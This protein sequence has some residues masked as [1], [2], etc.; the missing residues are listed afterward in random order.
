[1]YLFRGVSRPLAEP[2]ESVRLSREGLVF[3][4][5][6]FAVRRAY[7][8]YG[9]R[10]PNFNREPDD[11]IGLEIAFL[12]NLASLYAE[13]SEAGEAERIRESMT[14][15]LDEHLGAYYRAV[16]DDVRKHAKTALYKAVAEFT[17]GFVRSVEDFVS[18]P[19]SK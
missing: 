19:A 3:D 14:E 7:A 5:E 10:A 6:T 11:H 13:Q 12:T 18:A 17:L 4:E 1:L 9:F 2:H 16:V 15:F 8:A